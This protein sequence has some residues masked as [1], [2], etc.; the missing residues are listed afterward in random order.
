MG[1]KAYLG[2]GASLVGL[3][4]VGWLAAER[5]A[6]AKIGAPPPLVPVTAGIAA[7]RDVPA[8]VRG[9]GTV[10]AYNMVAIKSRVDGHITRV[11]FEEG[12]EVAAGDPLFQIDPR[13]FQAALAQIE[14]TKDKDEAQ[15]RAAQLD[16]DRFTKL[17]GRGFQSRQGYDNQKAAVEQLQG[18]VK[19]DEAQIETAELN[20]AYADI[21]SPISGRTG[22][23]LVDLGNLVQTSQGTTLTTITQIKPIFVSFTIPQNWVD[24]LRRNHDLAPLTV[25]AY[26]SDDRQLLSQGKLSLIDNHIDAAS[27]TVRLKAVFDNTDE[28]LWPGEFVSARVVVESRKNIVTVP[29]ETIMQG[30]NGAYVYIIKDD[31]TV[32][33]KTV[34]LAGAQ[35]G[36]AI[37]EAGLEAGQRIVVK[38]Q[39]RLTNGLKVSFDGPQAASSS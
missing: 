35:D 3:A 20:L 19:A 38:G 9:I 5:D 12:R 1:R 14:A 33:R 10:Q 21:R 27:G 11:S 4:V 7:A 32:Q 24:A 6:P 39:Y 2:F 8:Y 31:D 34:Q 29:A 37:I 22:A 36:F 25:L 30:P 16:L 23:R 28:R 17:L 18:A 15:L 26:A 13:P